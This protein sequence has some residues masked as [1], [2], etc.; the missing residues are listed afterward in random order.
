MIFQFHNMAIT[1]IAAHVRF[2]NNTS[3][4]ISPGSD[5]REKL[6]GTAGWYTIMMHG[7]YARFLI[8][9]INRNNLSLKLRD[10]ETS[11]DFLN[12]QF[13]QSIKQLSSFLPINLL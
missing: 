10:D 5:I 9:L 11:L 3:T 7:K 1:W 6:W 8:Y 13:F 4:P 12:N 2:A